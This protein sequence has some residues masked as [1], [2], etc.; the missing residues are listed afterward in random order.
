MKVQRVKIS[1]IL[2]VESLEF[3]TGRVTVIEGANGVG[4]SSVLEALK[5]CLLGGHNA[6]LLRQGADKGE[7]VLL[8]DD[9]LEIRKTVT[10]SGSTLKVT[11]PEFGPISK[12]QT[13]LQ[14]LADALSVNPVEFLTASDK[15]RVSLLLE[16]IPMRVT[17]EQIAEAVPENCRPLVAGISTDAHAL[18]VIAAVGKELYGQRTGVNRAAKEKRATA[19]QLRETLPEEPESGD[20][21]QEFEA[22]KSEYLALQ[23][24]AQQKVADIKEGAQKLIEAANDAERATTARIEKELSDKTGQLKAEAAA[25]IQAIQQ[26]L[27]DAVLKLE[28]EADG[29]I[30]SARAAAEERREAARQGKDRSLAEAQ[31]EYESL[32]QPLTEALTRAKT[33]LEQQTKARTTVELIDRLEGEAGRLEETSEAL[34]RALANLEALKGNLLESLPVKGL[35]IRDGSIYLDGIPF[36]RVNTA[37]QIQLAIEVA[38]LRAGSLGLVCV[39]NLEHLDPDTFKAFVKAAQKSKLQFVVSRVTQGPLTVGEAEVV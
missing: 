8:L 1:N 16:A 7:T 13:Y 20:W 14:K 9:D 10:P 2:G 15:E 4:K 18:E 19:S 29:A 35:E 22:R 12:G 34:T 30:S 33:M 28:T 3:D 26:Q 23:T 11:H 31:A 5:S 24:A 37:K 36:D 39:D 21:S 6:S 32:N 17:E 38:G 25:K 27:A